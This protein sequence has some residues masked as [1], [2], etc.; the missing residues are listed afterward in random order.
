LINKK[1]NDCFFVFQVNESEQVKHE[2]YFFTIHNSL[3][4]LEVMNK[5]LLVYQKSTKK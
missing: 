2:I 5:S 3:F 1:P 4:S